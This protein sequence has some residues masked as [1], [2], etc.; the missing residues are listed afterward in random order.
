MSKDLLVNYENQPCYNIYLRPDFNDLAKLF[1]QDTKAAYDK[2]CIVADSNTSRL[3]LDELLSIFKSFN[4]PVTSFV[5]EAGEASKNL[6]TVQ[7]LYEHLVLF[8]ATRHSL[9]V[10]LGG[11]VVGDLTGFTAATYMRGIDFIQ[12]PT[13]LL[14][15]VDSS[16]GGK[17]GVDFNQYKNMVG[18]FYMPRLV[19]MN[20]STLSTLD[21][22]NFSCGMGEVIKSALIQN[23]KLYIWLKEN[24]SQVCNRDFDSLEYMI[25]ECC[26]IKAHV[27]E[28]DPK[29]HGIRAFLNYGHTLG[30]AIEKLSDFSLGHGQCVALGMV[31]ANYLSK[32]LG[33]LT[34][35]QCQEIRDTF[36]SYGLP[37]SISGMT[38]EDILKAS[39]SDKK[40]AAGKI[41]FI[42]LKTIGQADSYMDF[43][44]Q[45]LLEAIE[46]VLN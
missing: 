8:K 46:K 44:D 38:K 29:E 15:Q 30:H 19:Y 1:E 23:D 16:I 41:K 25:Y 45:D 3:Y 12:V 36:I 31:C 2:I 28:L 13:T 26:R 32:K 24:Y 20:L 22:T 7:K 17:T 40:M 18:A 34:E 37:V 33:F 42:V 10:A 43:T 35:A 27:V 4:V 14:A 39:K 11:G 6:N 9:L 21:D 5:F